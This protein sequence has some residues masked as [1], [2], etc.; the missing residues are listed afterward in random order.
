[1]V[2]LLSVSLVAA[3][4]GSVH[5]KH[6]KHSSAGTTVP[7]SPV[8][9][10]TGKTYNV[11]AYGADPTGA[12]DSTLAIRRA[13]AAAEAKPGSVLFFPPGRYILAHRD[14]LSADFKITALLHIEGAGPAQTTLVEEE[15]AK[16][17]LKRGKMIFHLLPAKGGQPG[18]AD[19]SSISGLTLDSATYDGGTTILDNANR[20]E[21]SNM[22][23][24]GPRSNHN[25]NKGQFGMRVVAV[26]KHDN[27]SSHHRSDNTV[28]NI[29]ITGQGRAGNVDLD[30]SCQQH[31]TIS[32]INDTG[33]GVALYIDE[34]ITLANLVFHPGPGLTAPQ[35]YVVTAPTSD[36][37]IS[38]V[39]TYG[40]GGRLEPSP[41]H[42][43]ISNLVITNEQMVG[44][45]QYSL[46][47]GDVSGVKIVNSHISSLKLAPDNG[48]S[49]LSVIG[50]TVG[51]TQ[52]S[53]PVSA[54]SL[55]G[56]HC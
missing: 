50:S 21:I 47:L 31:D 39:M 40:N 4:C 6:H 29:T 49:N 52:C 43:S 30:I 14:K 7:A 33:N 44:G 41:H 53:G 54:S 22:V 24:R 16:N 37:S 17:G 13:I 11:T 26:C 28:R 5:H 48:L 3:A 9:P 1:V 27:F 45:P 38:N 23:I 18:G 35:P 32:N 15:G 56:V 10:P 20:T 8:T 36:V 55:T 12:R 51:S 19:G 42:Y 46:S 25:Y 34:G 2:L